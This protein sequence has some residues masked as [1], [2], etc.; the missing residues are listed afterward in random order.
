MIEIYL[1]TNTNYEANG[2]ITLEPTSCIYNSSDK[3][4]TLEHPLDDLG[5][6]KYIQYDNVLAITRNGKK[7][8]YRI[9]NIVKSLD[10]ITA[11]ARPLAF[12]L[13]DHV[14]IDVRPTGKT[15]QEA[16][17]II[18]SGTNFKGH[19]NLSGA[20]TAYYIRKNIIEA[21]LGDDENSFINRWGGEPYFENYDI[22]INERLGVNNGVR[23]SFGYNLAA[24]EEDINIEEVATRIIPTGYNGIMLEGNAPWVDS[25][26]INKYAN[27]KTRVI[28]FEDIKVK[29]SQDDEEGFNTIQE[30]R[31]AL[32][33]RCQ[34]LFENGI[35]KPIISY[36]IDMINLADTTAYEEFKVLNEANEGDTVTCYVKHLDI[37]VEARVVNVELDEITGKLINIELGNVKDNFFNKQADVMNRVDN[38]LNKVIDS[39]GNVRAQEIKGFIDATKASIKAQKSIAQKQDVRAIECEDSDASSSNYG[40][41]IFGSMGLMVANTKDLNG[42]WD[43]T[44]ALTARGLVANM[45]YGKILAGTGVYFDLEKGEV[46]FNKGKIEGSNSSFN[47]DTGE[48][49][50][51]QP[52]GSEIIISPTQGFYNR[53]GTSKRRYHHLNFSKLIKFPADSLGGFSTVD[54]Q[55]PSEFKGKTLQI[56]TS[57]KRLVC[58]GGSVSNGALNAVDSFVEYNSSTNVAKVYGLLKVVNLDNKQL[59]NMNQYLE[60]QLE[61][62]A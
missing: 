45:L 30:A 37:D 16:L 34:E 13:I 6:W 27:I 18:L 1:K 38:I 59:I 22:Y 25:P 60:V 55:L 3:I 48:I 61:V 24:I 39:D 47:L 12:D 20:N 10:F 5:R 9:F 57:V 43:Y 4:E 58:D 29:D 21:L 23:I 33:R 51:S 50:C 46:Y 17:D 26:N 42:E 28:N 19:S 44:S 56:S 53:F 54:V 31:Q 15:A 35:D 2:D 32:I 14:L 8:L 41:S 36:N 49:K 7:K 11:Y 62:I 40:S 52:D